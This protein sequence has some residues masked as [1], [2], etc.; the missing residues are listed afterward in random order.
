LDKVQAAIGVLVVQDEGGA[1]NELT[2]SES[3]AKLPV[4]IEVLISRSLDVLS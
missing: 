1:G 3:V 4:S 2:T